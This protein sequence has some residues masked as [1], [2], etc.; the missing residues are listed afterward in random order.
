MTNRFWTVVLLL[1]TATLSALA[2]LGESETGCDMRY[3]KGAR[4]SQT[5]D[6]KYYPL[7][8]G[9]W[10]TNKTYSY[11]GW[12]IKAG[13]LKGFACRIE[14]RKI[15]SE[16]ISGDEVNA[17]L[18]ANGGLKTWRVVK[19]EQFANPPE[20]LRNLFLHATSDVWHRNDGA[21]AY[22][23]DHMGRFL[24]ENRAARA[25]DLELE[26]ASRKPKTI[27]RF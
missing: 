19:V 12:K 9:N 24:L 23:D 1:T 6:D 16:R 21:F 25:R 26:A 18:E 10:T 27:P 2:R 22:S 7:I 5:S 14:Y 20:D 4:L 13:F 17:I 3:N 8:T 11:E 15:G